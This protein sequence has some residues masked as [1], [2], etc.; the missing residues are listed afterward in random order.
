M[1]KIFREM[2]A[3]EE[4]ANGPGFHNFDSILHISI[5]PGK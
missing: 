4:S 5:Q 1:G 2:Q 3:I